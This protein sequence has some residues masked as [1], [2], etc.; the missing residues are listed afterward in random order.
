MEQRVER[1]EKRVVNCSSVVIVICRLINH[2]RRV[3]SK[4]GFAEGT[5]SCDNKEFRMVF[6]EVEGSV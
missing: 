1:I 5:W 4:L 6:N 3:I 2:E